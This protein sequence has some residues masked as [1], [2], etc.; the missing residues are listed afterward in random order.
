MN[1]RGNHRDMSVEQRSL[2]G[3]MAIPRREIL[4]GVGMTALALCEQCVV[5]FKF[6]VGEGVDIRPIVCCRLAFRRSFERQ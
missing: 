3:A 1:L 4:A 6:L 5:G 2:G